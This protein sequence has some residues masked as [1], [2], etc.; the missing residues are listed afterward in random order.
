VPNL[1]ESWRSEAGRLRAADAAFHFCAVDGWRDSIA[2]RKLRFLD[3]PEH[4]K[5]QK[6]DLRGKEPKS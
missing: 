6:L 2:T 5:K 1:C 3:L 4:D